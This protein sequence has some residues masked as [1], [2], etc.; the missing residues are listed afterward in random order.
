MSETYDEQFDRKYP[1]HA[2]LRES[3]TQSERNAMGEFLEWLLVTKGYDLVEWRNYDGFSVGTPTAQLIAEFFEVDYDAFQN[4]KDR[5]YDEIV[6]D[7]RR[8]A[9]ENPEEGS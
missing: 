9:S 5:M 1:M 6:A 3:S 8:T 2:K 4:E 7:T